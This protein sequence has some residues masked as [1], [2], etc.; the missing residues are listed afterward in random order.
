MSGLFLQ[1]LGTDAAG[2][3]LAFRARLE[4][5][6]IKTVLVDLG[7]HRETAAPASFPNIHRFTLADPDTGEIL[8]TFDL[9]PTA[10]SATLASPTALRFDLAVRNLLSTRGNPPL[11]PHPR[12]FIQ[13][14]G[15][16]RVLT[17]GGNPRLVFHQLTAI[18]DGDGE[19]TLHNP[20]SASFGQDLKLSDLV[21]KS[22]KVTPRNQVNVLV[23]ALDLRVELSDPELSL[24]FDPVEQ[25]AAGPRSVLVF[26]QTKRLEDAGVSFRGR[27][28]GTRG[29]SLWKLIQ[30]APISNEDPKRENEGK[31]NRWIVSIRTG[32]AKSRDLFRLWSQEIAH[33]YIEALRTIQGGRAIS[34]ILDF[35]IPGQS[36]PEIPLLLFYE[37][38]E[39]DPAHSFGTGGGTTTKLDPKRDLDFP[40]DRPAGSAT[41]ASP[42]I[43]GRVLS[44]QPDDKEEIHPEI[45]ARFLGLLTHEG[46]PLKTRWKVSNAFL[47][48]GFNP[49][50]AEQAHGITFRAAQRSLSDSDP[51]TVRV[52]SLDLT[53]SQKD[54]EKQ[55]SSTFSG[56]IVRSGG[57]ERLDVEIA[58][59]LAVTT[60]APGG[61]DG[62]PQDEFAQDLPD[63]FERE[64][65]IVIPLGPPGSGPFLLDVEETTFHPYTRE[66]RSQT[67]KMRLLDTA[68][69]DQPASVQ[70]VVV[71][72][73]QPFL[74]AKVD[75]PPFRAVGDIREVGN[76]SGDSPHGASWELRASDEI[77]KGFTM[78]L[79]PQ[80]VGEAMEKIK[81]LI[82]IE[83]DQPTDVP[84]HN[85]GEATEE[86]KERIDIEEGKPADF[87]FTP[88]ARFDL[89]ASF[90][91]QRFA[92]AP[93]N[94]RRILGYPGQRAPGAGVR[95]L[96][97]EMLY[98]M[99]C[100]VDTPF[101]HLAEIVARLGEIPG[102]LPKKL[103]WKGTPEQDDALTAF[104]KDWGS[105]FERYF[106]RLAILEP[107]DA[108]QPDELTL[109]NGVHYQLRASADLRFPVPSEKDKAGP[110]IPKA[111]TGLA[112]GVGWGFESTNIY[113]ATWRDPKSTSGKLVR[114]YFSALGGW[115]FQKASFDKDRTTIYSDTAMGRTFFLSL[116]RIGRIGTLWNVAKHV[117]I[118]ERTV[119]PSDQFDEDQ[120]HHAGRPI[121]RKV[122]EFVEILQPTR[123]YP[124]FGAAPVTRGFI[125]A[126]E[127]KS[128]IIHV[129]SSWGGDVGTI[130]WQVPLWRPGEDE[131]VFPKPQILLH[132]AADPEAGASTVGVEH[133]EPEKL[134][135]YTDTRPETDA[136]TDLWP[137]IHEIDYLDLPRPVAP[138][139]PSSAGED[140]DGRLPDA[141]AV[142]PGYE[143]F[144][145][146]VL[147]AERGT[148]VVLERADDA[149][150]AVIRNVTMMRS[151]PRSLEKE[152]P[153]V[154]QE[155]ARL[156][157]PV[158]RLLQEVLARVPTGGQVTT[159]LIDRL[160][161]EIGLP[162]ALKP[163]EEVAQKI[164]AL[165][166][167]PNVDKLL[168]A[169]DICEA[170]KK[171]STNQ[172]NRL[173]GEIQAIGDRVERELVAFLR[174][175][176]G[177]ETRRFEAHRFVDEE[178]EKLRRIAR[179]VQGGLDLVQGQV[180]K[181]L[182]DL[183]AVLGRIDREIDEQVARIDQLANPTEL[184]IARLRG[185]LRALRA[186]LAA[187]L[188]EVD[189]RL[190]GISDPQ[191]GKV[192][193]KIRKWLSTALGT[194]N[195]LLGEADGLLEQGAAKLGEAREKLQQIKSDLKAAL[196]NLK[197]SIKSEITDTTKEAFEKIAE[198]LK[199]INTALDSAQSEAKKAI[200]TFFD[201]HNQALDVLGQTLRAEIAAAL[202]VILTELENYKMKIGEAIDVL[203]ERLLQKLGDFFG[204]VESLIGANGQAALQT[205]RGI[206]DQFPTGLPIEKLKAALA[207]G[208]E[209]FRRE[210]AP[211]ADQLQK[212]LQDALG[213]A[214]AQLADNTLRLL[215][216]FGDAPI[217][218]GLDFN[219]R[220]IAYFFDELK[221]AVD[222]TPVVALVNR[223]GDELKGLGL[224]I[225]TGQ[226]LDRIL[227][228]PLQGFDLS[229][230]FPDFAGLKLDGLFPGLRMPAIANDNVKVTHGVDPQSRRAWVQA[231]VGVPVN[232]PTNVFS[233]GPIALRLLRS[234]FQARARVEA[235]LD[236]PPR[237]TVSG[238]IT[239]DWQISVLS[240]PIVLFRDTALIFEDGRLRFDLSPDKVELTAALRFLAD[241]M[242]KIGYSEGGFSVRLLE[243]GG[244][245][246]GVQSVL[247]LPLPDMA[248]GA[249]AVTSLRLGSTF[250]L[251]VRPAAGGI[252]F[253]LSTTFNLGRKEAPFALA[254][255][256]LTGGGWLEAE[257]SYAPRTNQLATRVSVGVVAGGSLAFAFGPVRGGVYLFFGIEAEFASRSGAGG[258]QSLN[259]A[260]L[261]LVRGEVQIFGF[262]SVGIHLLLQAQYQQSGRLIGTG[263]LSLSIKISWFVT[264]RVRTSVRY[265]FAKGSGGG[266]QNELAAAEADDPI[267]KAA[268]E[269][270]GM[271]D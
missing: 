65:A 17:D 254:I 177:D 92:E 11:Q 123:S 189:S 57:I 157:E 28:V 90:F 138:A 205:L 26:E 63:E 31:A 197:A 230:I 257:A 211:L 234:R 204:S 122:E 196:A 182:K 168:A 156:S 198:V 59:Q 264:I 33:P 69:E 134:V 78:H 224:R 165:R 184:E 221:N 85:M 237:Q 111:D 132:M 37:L 246:V 220:Q 105:I 143:R 73:R 180:E 32:D 3:K 208:I 128:R 137:A 245:P 54:H 19:P 133:A 41:P 199:A 240:T 167:D 235:T 25:D 27:R 49:A 13:L 250:T 247:D 187:L 125:T 38:R 218:P 252:D 2:R 113:N 160:K 260:I 109:D 232:E 130:G 20:R 248:A 253:H 58:S 261:L 194:V 94:L 164:A 82:D 55:K 216:A 140:L 236:G 171:E 228:N 68:P 100:E 131:K 72:D 103:P 129:K 110:G 162:G 159:E 149:L 81:N 16:I 29:E 267:Q 101:L 249:F 23:E 175:F 34:L 190:A 169:T 71:L 163:L 166:S 154:V 191:L 46:K 270:I 93:W 121:L 178:I 98:G 74:V 259:I 30:R 50:A 6:T 244:L 1:L 18:F 119:A 268:T 174:Q 77:K 139:I 200:D 227:P 202:Q 114:P 96:R 201:Q 24:R 112:G 35:E 155:V 161:R 126:S 266:S 62:L 108:H 179:L 203:C 215:R 226:L 64:R 258:G 104:R 142:A 10:S 181:L 251:R 210:L 147:P 117:I 172:L 271:L 8:T 188:R 148:N 239:G 52:G 170:L 66:P 42:R 217:V 153:R 116:E 243:E 45:S 152:V 97:F 151:N 262:I 15:E 229:K 269:Y 225:P 7:T 14:R 80:G 53:F 238:K 47:D 79:P 56:D 255:A 99:E 158:D 12:S 48:G 88:P 136:R 146:A 95:N 120:D 43:I 214:V 127:F 106:S 76:W 145:W 219:R 209:D 150:A 173:R 83:E 36:L 195:T 176:E 70:S 144:T 206:L 124:E 242:K 233:T 51:R 207:N 141:P 89:Q 185:E 223:I 87:K 40:E 21:G 60:A 39:P 265:E 212:G 91:E 5:T 192:A 44:L 241:L 84:P 115:G 75:V 86:I 61:Q 67:L 183:D 193:E 213:G 263:T 186:R 9:L 135:F 222:L 4:G 107:W 102:D 118:Y 256:I 22:V 231:D